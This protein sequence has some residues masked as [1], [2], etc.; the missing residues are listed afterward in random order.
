MVSLDLFATLAVPEPSTIIAVVGLGAMG[1]VS[2][3]WQWRKRR[4]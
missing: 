4:S 2:L 1:L 3:L